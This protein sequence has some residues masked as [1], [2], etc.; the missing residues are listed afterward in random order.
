VGSVA[1]LNGPPRAGLQN[2]DNAA[3]SVQAKSASPQTLNGPLWNGRLSTTN[4]ATRDSIAQNRGR[5]IDQLGLLGQMI[6]DAFDEGRRHVDGNGRDVVGVGLVG[7]QIFGEA[8]D[9]QGIAPFGDEHD[10][11]GVGVGGSVR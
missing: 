5:G 10:L 11:A 3:R 4:R 1:G 6:A 7:A 9:G 2:L 8:S